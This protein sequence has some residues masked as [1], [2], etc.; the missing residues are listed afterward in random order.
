MI[1][2]ELK[3]GAKSLRSWR[4]TITSLGGME[5]SADSVIKTI[6][7]EELRE[8]NGALKNKKNWFNYIQN[9]AIDGHTYQS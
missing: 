9:M 8:T 2:K 6:L 4:M 7:E 3:N 1:S 5:N